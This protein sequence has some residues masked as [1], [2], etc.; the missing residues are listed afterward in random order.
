MAMLLRSGVAAQ[1]TPERSEAALAVGIEN[2]RLLS[3]RILSGS[4]PTSPAAFAWL[5]SQGVQT[6]VS[7]DAAK[8]RL[9]LARQYGLH[10]VHIPFGYDA[11][12]RHAADS[13]TAVVRQT[14][15]AIY[16]HCHHGK[17]RG[18]AA[19]AIASMAEGSADANSAIRILDDAGTDKDYVGLWRD[20]RAYNVP[21]ADTTLPTLVEAVEAPSLAVTMAKL[22]RRFDQLKQFR[23]A[24]WQ[25]PA[26]SSE[27]TPIHEALLVQEILHEATRQE[28]PDFDDR[29]R[30]WLKQSEQHALKTYQALQSS[31]MR[32]EAHFIALERSCRQCHKAYR[33][34]E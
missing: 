5:K 27:R 33:D 16:I 34:G 2:V 14:A 32:A 6:I 31:P 29:F 17:H 10:Y 13:L 24:N 7:V 1:D 18:A 25:V 19:A 8:P 9:D 22:S 30:T 21:A 15:G 11:I 20:V 12:P 26:A 3:S 4:E 28:T 23:E